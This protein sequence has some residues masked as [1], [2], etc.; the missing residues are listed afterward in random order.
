ML[1]EEQALSPD[2]IEN[3]VCKPMEKLKR[4]PM[5]QDTTGVFVQLCLMPKEFS[6]PE[7]EKP[8]LYSVIEKRIE[9]CYTFTIKDA[10]LILAIAMLSETPGS[11]VLYL[12]YLQYWCKQNDVKELSLD[13][14]CSDV[15][16]FGF[17]SKDDLHTIWNSQKIAGK[18]QSYNL[19][20]RSQS[21]LS[22]QF[23]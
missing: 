20:D 14:F 8:F 5:D 6:I 15:F 11:A 3:I 18:D 2:A 1:Q 19:V 13:Q 10:R 4:F 17:P 22:V 23:V 7:K 16:P 21:G 12:W 9:H